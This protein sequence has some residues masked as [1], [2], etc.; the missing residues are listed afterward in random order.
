MADFEIAMRSAI[1]KCFEGGILQGCFFH[2]CKSIWKKIK[3]LHLFKKELREN[4][5][6]IAFIMKCFPLIKEDKKENYCKKMDDI[7]YIFKGNYLKLRKYFYKYWRNTEIFN[8][9]NLD[10]DTIKN[11]TNNIVESFHKKL[12]HEIK[13][14]HPRLK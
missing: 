13:H 5:F 14:Y 10:N 12:N 1:K 7:F 9:T 2:F 8:F 3:K 4:T 11:R 6:I